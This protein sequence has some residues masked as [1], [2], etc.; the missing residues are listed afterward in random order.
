MAWQTP[1]SVPTSRPG[2]ARCLRGTAAR[3]TGR[4]TRRQR[5]CPRHG[6]GSGGGL[7]RLKEAGP[8]ATGWPPPPPQWRM[9]RT[10]PAWAPRPAAGRQ[11]AASAPDRGQTGLRSCCESAGARRT[12]PAGQPAAVSSPGHCR[13][14]SRWPRRAC[15][16]PPLVPVGRSGGRT[17]CYETQLGQHQHVRPRPARQVPEPH[18]FPPPPSPSPSPPH[19]SWYPQQSP[20][21]PG[22][23]RCVVSEARPPR[24]P[25]ESD[26]VACV[27]GL[28]RS[29]SR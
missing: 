21:S 24:E 5:K 8:A 4:Q 18:R 15:A 17:H 16:A 19:R 13:T 27:P 20:G 11:S 9:R 25:R 1:R 26:P 2:E 29:G 3:S 14:G 6:R 22:Q 10:E 7:G 23:R 28:G 12:W